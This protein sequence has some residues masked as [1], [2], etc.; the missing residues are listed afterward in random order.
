MLKLTAELAEQMEQSEALDMR[1]RQNLLKI[2][3]TL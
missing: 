3:F 2:G 1:I